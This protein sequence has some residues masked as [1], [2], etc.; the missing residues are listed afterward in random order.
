[1]CLFEQKIQHFTKYQLTLNMEQ[2][3]TW[4]TIREKDLDFV[5][6]WK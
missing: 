5:D 3:D 1:M 6:F 2:L 4:A